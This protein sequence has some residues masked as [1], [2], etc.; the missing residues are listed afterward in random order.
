MKNVIVGS[1][2]LILSLNSYA[3]VYGGFVNKK[4]CVYFKD[5]ASHR[6]DCSNTNTMCASDDRCTV[7]LSSSVYEGDVDTLLILKRAEQ[8]LNLKEHV[9]NED[10]VIDLRDTKLKF[11]QILMK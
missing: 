9:F 3:T 2:I 4:E 5:G 7:T 11:E 1:A 6:S 8:E 10:D